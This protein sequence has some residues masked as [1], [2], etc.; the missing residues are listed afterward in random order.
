MP[1]L[2][3]RANAVQS[4]FS[5][6]LTFKVRTLLKSSQ[7]LTHKGKTIIHFSL[8][9]VFGKGC[10]KEGSTCKSATVCLKWISPI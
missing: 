1:V 8:L 5:I 10:L 7:A 3:L 4:S 9:L 6:R 2:R